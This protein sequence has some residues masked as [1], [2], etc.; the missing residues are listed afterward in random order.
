[1]DSFIFAL[2]L[3]FNDPALNLRWGGGGSEEGQKAVKC[4]MKR[5]L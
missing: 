2:C 4:E 1:M 5:Y 3:T